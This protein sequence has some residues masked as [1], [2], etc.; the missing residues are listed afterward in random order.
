MNNN[1]LEKW[2]IFY[3]NNNNNINISFNKTILSSLTDSNYTENM[4]MN[5]PQ[6][7]MKILNNS[8][9]ETE[10]NNDL[11]SVLSDI[12]F[13]ND[14]NTVFCDSDTVFCDKE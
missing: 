2:N 9:N 6:L 7:I 4:I 14:L 8:N 3:N 12:I 1:N 11:N 13:N 5:S 10:M